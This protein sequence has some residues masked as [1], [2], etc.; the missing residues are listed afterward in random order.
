[1]AD[2]GKNTRIAKTDFSGRD[3]AGQEPGQHT[4][5]VAQEVH[6][7]R[8][9]SDGL[10]GLSSAISSFLGQATNALSSV[11][12]GVMYGEKAKIEQQNQSQKEQALGD[13]L[14]GKP[15]DSSLQR[16]GD[17][18]DAYRS[19]KAQ[20]DGY[21]AY[22]DFNKWYL[23]D[24]LPG[25][26][27]GDLQSARQEWAKQNLTGSEDPSY[28][29]QVLSAFYQNSDSMI[30]R[31][32]EFALKYQTAQGLENF[33]AAVDAQVASGTMDVASLN[34]F[35][36]KLMVLDPLNSADAPSRLAN[37]LLTSAQ[38]HPEQMMTISHL[39]GQEGTG[40]NGKSF[41][42][43]WPDAY[44]DFQNKAVSAWNSINS[45]D[46]LKTQTDLEDRLR[47]A[48]SMDDLVQLGVDTMKF[49]QKAGAMSATTSLMN[50]ISAK[51]A[52]FD[53]QETA[54]QGIDAFMGGDTASAD[55]SDVRKNFDGW[56]A[57]TL[58]TNNVLKLDPAVATTMIHHLSGVVPDGL[59]TQ[60]SAAL[61]DDRNP[62]AQGQAI[63]IMSGLSQT[64]GLDYAKQYLSGPA[65]QLF[66]QVSSI[67]AVG[68]D[69]METVLKRVNDARLG[70]KNWDADWKTITGEAD[71]TKAN[72]RVTATIN[73]TLKDTLGGQGGLLGVGSQGAQVPLDLT[74]TVMDLAR[75]KAVEA[76]ANGRG[77]EAGVKDAITEVASNAEVIPGAN[78]QLFLSLKASQNSTYLDENGHEAT[79]PRLG[80]NVVN[81][82]T[83]VAVNTLDV[84]STQLNQAATKQSWMFPHGVS[85]IHLGD[86]GD[87]RYAPNGLV[88]VLDDALPIVYAAG[89]EVQL[90][91]TPKTVM[92]KIRQ[93]N[94]KAGKPSTNVSVAIPSD[95]AGMEK[96]FGNLPEGFKF[97]R[98]DTAHGVV[99][100]L[101]YRPNYGD[102]GGM[103]LDQR[104][105]M[106][107]GG[108]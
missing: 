8:S 45:V 57:R 63:T 67:R 43:S 18:Y 25:N 104:A 88:P 105:S 24:W 54:F 93:D 61:V 81:P 76:Q 98:Q 40:V 52:Q 64:A 78:G 100:L 30:P 56:M 87:P 101:G 108:W 106:N 74:K 35:K 46:A 69:S 10:E 72:D 89:Q 62:A 53:Q 85:G 11:Q 75:Q 27:T 107:G 58:G 31:H 96:L 13:A 3:Y 90:D 97:L 5:L 28:E 71:P 65:A 51:A 17:Y 91:H 49:R 33:G 77:W 99:W 80:P 94:S 6:Q 102:K 48:T 12:Q 44:A 39:L 84:Y 83:G 14:A 68:N 16:D 55:P 50:A 37:A 20:R 21:G 103:S 41:A 26:P 34:D 86:P 66:D 38:N 42:Q 4:Q 60:L 47:Q 1:M 15:M 19:V 70:I 79:R 59:K 32:Q 2:T 73:Q 7:F 95:E 92:E 9:A 82:K 36:S 23:Q 22:Q 29:G